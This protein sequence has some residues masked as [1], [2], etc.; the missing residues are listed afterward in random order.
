M[1][2]HG[3]MIP[4]VGQPRSATASPGREA[5]GA[6][7]AARGGPL[8]RSMRALVVEAG[9]RVGSPTPDRFLHAATD[10]AVGIGARDQH[11]VGIQAVSRVDGRAVLADGVLATHD[12]LAR[13]VAAPL[14]K[15]LV[16]DVNARD[17]GFD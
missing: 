16:L 11:E 12:R 13:D 3:A 1:Q 6:W 15:H 8:F 7:G 10:R 2:A 9:V 5:W 17:T 4:P 14:R